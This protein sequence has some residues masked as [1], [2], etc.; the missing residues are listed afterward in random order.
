MNARFYTFSK[1]INSTARPTGG[2]NYTIKLKE[3]SSIIRPHLELIWTGAGSPT[4][5]NYVYLGDFSR[6]YWIDNW[7]YSERKWL[8]DCSVDPLA[9]WKMQIGNA[10]KYVLRA[11]SDYDPLVIDDFYP[12]KAETSLTRRHN[13]TPWRFTDFSRGRVVLSVAGINSG[14][15]TGGAG[16]VAYTPG[17]FQALLNE[18]FNYNDTLWNSGYS[19]SDFGTA[20]AEGVKRLMIS[21]KD[22][23]QFLGTARWFPFTPANDGNQYALKLAGIQTSAPCELV[24]NPIYDYSQV[25]ML[26]DGL[27]TGSDMAWEKVYPFR[28]VLLW[29]PPFGLTELDTSRLIGHDVVYL[30]CKVDVVSGSALCSVSLKETVA[31]ANYFAPLTTIKANF[32]I[33]LD[34]G[35]VTSANFEQFATALIGGAAAA[36][37]GSVSGVAAS[38]ASVAKSF[39]PTVSG[40]GTSGGG[41]AGFDYDNI[42]MWEINYTH[43]DEDITEFGRPLCDVRVINTLSGYIQTQDGDISAPA[44]PEEL[45]AIATYLTGGFFYD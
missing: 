15:V 24:A 45:S 17:N 19:S 5:F 14:F 23:K 25:T 35:N 31:G 39:I 1:R 42:E 9:S 4:A 21:V 27:L 16:Y 2:V 44:T 40:S 36:Y 30:D 8:A 26:Y 13:N 28:R 10:S 7:T 12:A 18:V 43:P 41:Y 32:G 29:F 38:V 33:P 22:P 6:Y 20:I 34:I 3:P 11:A 37:A